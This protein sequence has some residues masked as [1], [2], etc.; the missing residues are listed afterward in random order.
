MIC[1]HGIFTFFDEYDGRLR[2]RSSSYDTH[3]L[4]QGG[5]IAEE[6]KSFANSQ[7]SFNHESTQR[8]LEFDKNFVSPVSS[9][10][11]R[12]ETSSQ[13]SSASISSLAS[14]VAHIL[15]LVSSKSASAA[16]AKSDDDKFESNV[17]HASSVGPAI[18]KKTFHPLELRQQPPRTQMEWSCDFL[19]GIEAAFSANG[20]SCLYCGDEFDQE[21]AEWSLKGRHLVDEHR[22]GECNLLL[23]YDSEMKFAQHVQEFHQCSIGFI[24]HLSNELLNKHRYFGRE[25]GFHRGTESKDQNLTDDFHSIRSQ[26]WE[27]LFAKDRNLKA[28]HNHH[29]GG[30]FIP[31]SESKQDIESVQRPWEPGLQAAISEEGCI[32]DGLMVASIFRPWS[33]FNPY[34]DE[35]NKLCYSLGD[36]IKVS[37]YEFDD[38]FDSLFEAARLLR[39]HDTTESPGLSG[40]KLIAKSSV[41]S[42]FSKGSLDGTE[43]TKRSSRIN[44]WLQEI[45]ESSSTTKI[46]MFHTMKN[47]GVDFSDMYTWVEKVLEFWEM[48]E[49]ATKVDEPDGLS[50]GAVDSRGSR[51]SLEIWE[52]INHD[53]RQVSR[54]QG[55]RPYF[56][57]LYHSPSGTTILNTLG[58]RH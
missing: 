13:M 53:A 37:R 48:D 47:H 36:G 8:F 54:P 40:A 31:S 19:P 30:K 25:M 51:G 34:G 57:S 55:C 1:S 24:Y 50:D 33:F 43:V 58:Q 15:E 44:S 29:V 7:T 26:R 10:L 18:S 42:R 32:V 56:T 12:L 23:A 5:V 28:K 4:K 9:Q 27:A 46:I 11:D 35:I 6:V 49:A 52:A 22:Y 17:G 39:T 2:K 41:V 16:S 20:F 21:S 3:I 38:R 14:D 45:L